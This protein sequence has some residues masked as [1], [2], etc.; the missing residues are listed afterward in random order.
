MNGEMPSR[1]CRCVG[2]PLDGRLVPLKGAWL[3]VMEEASR[4]VDDDGVAHLVHGKTHVYHYQLADEGEI[5]AVYEE[6]NS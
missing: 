6:P 1:L 3:V 5:L 4:G 2:G